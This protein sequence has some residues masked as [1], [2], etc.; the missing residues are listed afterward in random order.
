MTDPTPQ[1][2]LDNL[3]RILDQAARA[4]SEADGYGRLATTITQAA[5]RLRADA[6]DAIP[7]GTT[8]RAAPGA[9]G[10]LRDA[11]YTLQPDGAW[12]G[13]PIYR[14]DP[15]TVRRLWIDGLLVLAPG[16]PL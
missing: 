9:P 1:D 10:R 11:T 3:R 14:D 6:F 12:T 15:A 5:R 2:P 8:L 7:T 13:T 4:A 16:G